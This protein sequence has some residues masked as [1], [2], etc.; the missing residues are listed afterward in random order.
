MLLNYDFLELVGQNKPKVKIKGGLSLRATLDAFG[1]EL[2]RLKSEQ[3]TTIKATRFGGIVNKIKS[4][5]PFGTIS[6]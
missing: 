6:A 4:G 2:S 3:N 1:E 5:L